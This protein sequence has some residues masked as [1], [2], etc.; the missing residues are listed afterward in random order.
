M[1]LTV[2]HNVHILLT[3]TNVKELATAALTY[4]IGPGAVELLTILQQVGTLNLFILIL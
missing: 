3:E 4:A 2:Q 1:G